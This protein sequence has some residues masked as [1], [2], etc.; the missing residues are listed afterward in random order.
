[1]P[2]CVMDSMPLAV[3]AR[4]AT[5]PVT[6]VRSRAGTTARSPPSSAPAGARPVA[7]SSRYRPTAWKA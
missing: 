7:R 4:K 5:T 1:M 6:N 3:L 2:N